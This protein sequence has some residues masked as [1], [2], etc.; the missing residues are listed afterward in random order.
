MFPRPTGLLRPIVQCPTFRYKARARLGR[1]FTLEEVKEAGFTNPKTATSLGIAV[2][3]RRRNRS[4]Q[5]L[6]TNVQRLK[7]YQ[8]RLVVFP[9]NVKKPKAGDATE[10]ERAAVVQQ[11]GV[12]MPI[13]KAADELEFRA[14]TDE[15][16]KTSAVTT[17]KLAKKE[18]IM[19]RRLEKRRRRKWAKIKSKA[20]Q[21]GKKDKKKKKGK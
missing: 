15:D 7:E 8:A 18:A 19:S 20:A 17:L 21:A 14:I 9:K 1:G 3:Y 4:E 13:T 10:E 12:V 6:R 16:R 5:S 11:R 2:D